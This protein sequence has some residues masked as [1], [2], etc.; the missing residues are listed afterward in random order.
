[1]SKNDFSYLLDNELESLNKEIWEI[2]TGI[3][4]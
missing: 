1:M 3:K 2:E 4:R